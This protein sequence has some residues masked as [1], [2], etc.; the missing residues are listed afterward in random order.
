[1]VP[2]MSSFDSR[3]AQPA[4]S[5]GAATN[6]NHRV[7]PRRRT[8]KG[9]KIIFNQRSSVI[10]CSI[11][12]LSNTGAC[13]EVPSTVGIPGIFELR[14]EPGDGLHVCEVAWRNER[15]LGVRFE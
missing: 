6:A 15:R 3:K 1:M 11:V 13:L 10:T 4:Q 5:A 12:N 14:F 9:G 8:L 2:G 7:G